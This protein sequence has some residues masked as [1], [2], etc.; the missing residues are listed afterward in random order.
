MD[1]YRTPVDPQSPGNNNL[2][3]GP[4]FSVLRQFRKEP[5]PTKGQKVPF[6][7]LGQFRKEPKTTKKGKTATGTLMEP[8]RE[9]F[10]WDA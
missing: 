10:L 6:S 5:K 2:Q 9:P 8:P 7:V 3:K 4:P 1:P